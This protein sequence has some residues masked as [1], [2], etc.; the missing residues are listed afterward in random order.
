MKK[1]TILFCIIYCHDNNP[2]GANTIS[3][4]VSHILPSEQIAYGTWENGACEHWWQIFLI[5]TPSHST[6]LV[7]FVSSNLNRH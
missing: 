2:P 7:Q 5:Q 3:K 6:Y 1:N 4:L